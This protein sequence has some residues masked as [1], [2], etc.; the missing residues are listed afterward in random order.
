MVKVQKNVQSGDKRES[1]LILSFI[2]VFSFSKSNFGE[3]LSFFLLGR[4]PYER[5]SISVVK[6]ST[7]IDL[8]DDITH[9]FSLIFNFA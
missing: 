1:Q 8:E 9:I 4:K 3:L 6:S 5:T 2:H 7:L